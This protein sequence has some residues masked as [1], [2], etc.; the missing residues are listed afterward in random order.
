[1]KHIMKQ[2]MGKNET[3]YSSKVLQG[4]N[5]ERHFLKAR[6]SNQL[7]HSAS[8]MGAGLGKKP[9]NPNTKLIND[10]NNKGAGGTSG[11]NPT[12]ARI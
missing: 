1:M 5:N 8:P 4:G 12:Q 11:K 10:T 3:F 2:K 7:N 9:P 6:P